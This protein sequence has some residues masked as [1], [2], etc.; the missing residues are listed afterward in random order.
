MPTGS[1]R[2]RA[3]PSDHCPRSGRPFSTCGNIRGMEW[4][5]GAGLSYG[6]QGVD[7]FAEAAARAALGLGG[8][9]CELALVFA[10]E[11]NLDHAA[12]G[13]AAVHDRLRPQAL[14]GCGAQ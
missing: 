10:G 14:V 8:A 4:R 11:E 12:E 1:R 5:A 13:L 9:P 7:G 6:N 2:A 3:A